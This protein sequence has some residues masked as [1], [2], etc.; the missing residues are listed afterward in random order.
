[1]NVV[2]NIKPSEIDYDEIDYL[3]ITIKDGIPNE[4][5]ESIIKEGYKIGIQTIHLP[6]QKALIQFICSPEE[7]EKNILPKHNNQNAKEIY[8]YYA[9]KKLHSIRE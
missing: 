5:I 1:M 7:F 4:E 6:T 2:G 8:D 3:I 9:N